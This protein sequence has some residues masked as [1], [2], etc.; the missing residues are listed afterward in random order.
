MENQG[1]KQLLPKYRGIFDRAV[2]G[3]S[4]ADAIH[5]GCLI[6]LSCDTKAIRNCQEETCPYHPYRPYRDK[7]PDRRKIRTQKTDEKGKFL[8]KTGGPVSKDVIIQNVSAGNLRVRL[9]VEPEKG[10]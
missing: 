10:K 5:A 7:P 6:C 2:A 9:V 3:K 8:K 4:R 1:R